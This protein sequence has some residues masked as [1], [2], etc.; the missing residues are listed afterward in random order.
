M[1]CFRIPC[2]LGATVLALS[3][4]LYGQI[5]QDKPELCG[6]P[7]AVSVP[8]NIVASEFTLTVTL[9]GAATGVE[10]TYLG[11]V[12]QVCPIASNRYL[13][14]I[15]TLRSSYQIII[16][17]GETGAVVEKFLAYNP[18]VSPD[19]HWL[20]WRAFYAGMSQVPASEE[21]LLYDLTKDA[22]ENTVPA[23]TVYTQHLRGRVI[24]PAVAE[25]R[26]F[27]HMDL[28]EK[29]QHSFYSNSFYWSSDGTAIVFADRVQGLMSIVLVVLDPRGPKTFVHRVTSGEV[30]AQG[31]KGNILQASIML[32]QAEVNANLRSVQM[33]FRS[34][35]EGACS[36]GLLTL[37]WADF[38]PAA[39]EDHPP[40]VRT[41]I[42]VQIAPPL[43]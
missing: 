14:F 17:N 21:Y 31:S 25:G 6:K 13:V 39:L 41:G 34:S 5:T 16:L 19:Q 10:T 43:K 11:R 12:V 24:Y 33:Q 22:A 27:E 1:I 2:I 29:Q 42:P 38:E 18:E 7:D 35:D 26:P 30:C 4:V 20:V 23:P 40:I 32:S 36:P 37:N 15:D 3:C 28:P 9:P 8:R